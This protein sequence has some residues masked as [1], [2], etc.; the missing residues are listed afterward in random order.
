MWPSTV[1][2][3][4]HI[5]SSSPAE[6]FPWHMHFISSIKP[7]PLLYD[8]CYLNV[9]LPTGQIP[10]YQ[11]IR[12]KDSKADRTTFMLVINR[13]LPDYSGIYVC[14]IITNN[15]Q[16][17]FSKWTRKS[18]MLIVQVNLLSMLYFILQIYDKC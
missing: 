2:C 3:Q 14:T 6:H 5:S 16:T 7:Q 11:V 4:S 10:R 18:A 17:D 12:I 9:L 15:I 8:Y 1:E 13:L